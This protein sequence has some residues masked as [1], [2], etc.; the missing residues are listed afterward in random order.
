MAKLLSLFLVL[1]FAATGWA[2]NAY[3]LKSD[4]RERNAMMG[5]FLSPYVASGCTTT[6]VSGVTVSVAACTAFASNTAASVPELALARETGAQSVVLSTTDGTYWIV[7]HSKPGTSVAS[8][9]HQRG[10]MYYWQR[11]ATR[12]AVPADAVAIS[13][14]TVSG[15]VATA[16]S[17]VYDANP[18]STANNLSR[19]ATGCVPLSKANTLAFASALQEAVDAFPSTGGCIDASMIQGPATWNTT[20][21]LSKPMKI[22]LG[23]G[24]FTYAGTGRAINI[25]TDNVHIYGAG[26]GTGG[27]IL[28]AS[29]TSG[30][31]TG[32]GSSSTG[33]TRHTWTVVEDIRIIGNTGAIVVGS[34]GIDWEHLA[35]SAST[36]R[37]RVNFMEYGFRFCQQSGGFRSKHYDSEISAN[38]T[39]VFMDGSCGQDPNA[40]QFIV[41]RQSANTTGF[42]LTNANDILIDGIQFETYTTAINIASGSNNIRITNNRFESGGSV[43]VNHAIIDAGRFNTSVGNYH[44][45]GHSDAVLVTGTS[46]VYMDFPVT[47]SI[48]APTSGI[49][50]ENMLCNGGFEFDL[51][52]D[53]IPDCWDLGFTTNNTEVVSLQTGTAQTGTYNWRI[54]NTDS[55]NPRLFQTKELK[56]NNAYVLAVRAR[57]STGTN[58]C[59][60]RV[61]TGGAGSSDLDSQNVPGDNVWRT[62][63]AR[64]VATARGVTVSLYLNTSGAAQF[65]VDSV[66]LYEGAIPPQ[67]VDPLCHTWR[68]QALNFPN[69]LAQTTGE[70]TFTVQGALTAVHSVRV[71][72]PDSFEANMGIVG[73]NV[74]SDNTVTVR[75][76]NPTAGAINPASTTARYTLCG[77]D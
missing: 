49:G 76:M 69:V 22:F 43:G 31:P 77:R 60:I 3:N 51:D 35:D 42:Q 64:F 41:G 29:G 59:Q 57:C 67:F 32:I 52:N 44:S 4:Q 14:V 13:Q 15:G 45:S 47:P 50:S 11:N 46:S 53:G 25:T 73:A 21:N 36:T 1:A 26:R 39:G 9:T 72:L 38:T 62:F 37:V 66:G 48:I 2:D 27:T 54:V 17:H 70:T 34:R 10:T 6:V 5:A 8:W 30:N 65:D 55:V 58:V 7:A 12:P 23:P 74:T 28:H 24:T 63:Q 19:S 61:G 20:L 71:D 40:H 33:A 56:T 16:A 75:A 68:I 18:I